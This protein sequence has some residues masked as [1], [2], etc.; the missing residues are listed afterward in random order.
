ME[1]P[2]RNTKKTLE[3]AGLE[4]N[5]KVKRLNSY[6][7]SSRSSTNYTKP[8][9]EVPDLMIDGNKGN[10]F[11]VDNINDA[12]EVA[13][14]VEMACKEVL[15]RTGGAGFPILSDANDDSQ[16][17]SVKRGVERAT[18][19]VYHMNS[20]ER[21]SEAD[22]EDWLRRKRRGE[23]KRVLILDQDVSRGWEASHVLVVSLV[24]GGFENLVM[25]TVGYCTVVKNI[26]TI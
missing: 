25:R 4:A 12:D 13:S 7:G 14:Y 22:V 2:L 6:G 18:A 20:K 11:L 9:F 21:C 16:I 17:D 24:E 3:M 5:T 15:G 8:V 1:M 19:L 26:N 10:H 23:E